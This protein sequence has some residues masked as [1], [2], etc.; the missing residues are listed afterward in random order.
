MA[1]NVDIRVTMSL[2]PDVVREVEGF[3][4]DTA[5][6]L[7]PTITAFSEAYIGLGS[8]HTAREAAKKNPTLNEA[9]AVIN[10]QDFADKVF[11]RIARAM[12]STRASLTKTIASYEKD[13]S[14]PVE[15]KAAHPIASEIRAHVKGLTIG[16]RMTVIQKAIR[17]GD[18]AVATA[19]L[20][21]PAMLSG[22]DANTQQILTRQYH[23]HHNPLVARRL[24]ALKGAKALIEDRGGLVHKEM[25][26]AV[27]MAPHRVKA[28][29]DAKTLAE[30]AFILKDTV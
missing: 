23:E 15:S 2:H 19:I 29:R 11:A 26:K 21:A 17:E 18:I 7:A 25:E 6:L 8:I 3:D 24:R 28:L 14:Q 20:G 1:D 16:E 13:L 10:T 9:A 12:D 27:G 5:V 22:I 30:A 4:D